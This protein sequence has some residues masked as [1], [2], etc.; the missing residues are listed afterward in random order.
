MNGSPWLICGDFNLILEADERSTNRLTGMDREFRRLVNE[1]ALI[2]L[3]L[4]GRRYT[5]SNSRE[6]ATFV[7]LD[8]FLFS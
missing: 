7:R 4:Q 3:P 8:I 5:W 6:N 2:N 1:L